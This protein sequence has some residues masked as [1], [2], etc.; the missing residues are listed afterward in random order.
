MNKDLKKFIFL[1][2]ATIIVAFAISYSYSAYQNY[3]QEKK[4]EEVKKAFSFDTNETKEVNPK[5]AWQEQRLE[6]LESLG[7]TRVDIRPFYKRLYD[8]LTG[9][10]VYNYKSIDDETKTVTV[11][12]KD[13]KIVEKFFNGDKLTTNQELVANDDFTSYDLK[14]YDLDTK[15]V[16][17]FKD[18]LN[19]DTYLNTKNGIIEYE[20]GKTIE[21][22][23]QNGAMNGP[24]VE[25]L[26]NGD[27]I[28]FNFVNNKRVGEGEKFYKNGDREIFTYGENNLKNGTS[29]YYFA[30]GDVEE[31][32]YVNGVLQGP[33]K[34]TY[35]D[36]VME[37]YEY[38]DGK[39][40][41]N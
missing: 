5:E 39:R 32:T 1:L 33:A 40:I 34:Y 38:K 29:I 9:K 18:V 14:S 17:T 36:G 4:I 26:P 6:A 20:D 35:K 8:K 21:F 12:V 10:K 41:E 28:E 3:Q 11:E 2:I 19:N 31:T 24:A 25:N 30:N 16:T 15:V 22:T 13:N 7:Y 27:K 37:H 23:H